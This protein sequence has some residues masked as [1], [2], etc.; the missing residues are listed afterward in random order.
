MCRFVDIHD[1]VRRLTQA[2][3]TVQGF[4]QAAILCG[5]DWLL[6][7]TCTNQINVR[8]LMTAAFAVLRAGAPSLLEMRYFVMWLRL[9]YSYKLHKENVL[10]IEDL[11]HICRTTK[12]S[13]V[14]WPSE[15]EIKHVLARLNWN[16]DY[17]NSLDGFIEP[18]P[19]GWISAQDRNA[20]LS[21]DIF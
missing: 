17:W 19:K 7:Q 16:M 14:A 8:T 20:L 18:R 6:K 5:T 2:G 11:P 12:G 15:S 21:H 10:P 3:W 9:V 4:I 1:N 13:R